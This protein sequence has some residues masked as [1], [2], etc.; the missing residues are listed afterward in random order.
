[1]TY[2]KQILTEVLQSYGID[3]EEFEDKYQKQKLKNQKIEE[4]KK[5]GNSAV[6]RNYVESTFDNTE[7]TCSFSNLTDIYYLPISAKTDK[8]L[9]KFIFEEG[10]KIDNDFRI[11]NKKNRKIYTFLK[12]NRN[13][14]PVNKTIIKKI[15]KNT[16]TIPLEDVHFHSNYLYHCNN[17]L[18]I[19]LHKC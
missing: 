17:R 3:Y 11:E 10:R 8:L 19:I 9:T 16:I 1:M 7:Y 13:Y 4:I 5:I 12:T 2:S 15:G 14:D 6:F 18:T